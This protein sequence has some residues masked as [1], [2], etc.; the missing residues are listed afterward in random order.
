MLFIYKHYVILMHL[1]EHVKLLMF[2]FDD[3]NIWCIT[4]L[5][6]IYLVHDLS[7]LLSFHV[8]LKWI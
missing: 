4:Y 3:G 7:E 5:V 6:M 2:D 8:W 1:V